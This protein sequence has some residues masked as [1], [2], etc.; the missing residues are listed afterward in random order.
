MT[1]DSKSETRGWKSEA[2]TTLGLITLVNSSCNVDVSKRKSKYHARA[3][4]HA[5]ACHVPA[6]CRT[7]RYL[8]QTLGYMETKKIINLS[9]N[10]PAGSSL[11]IR[12]F[13]ASPFVRVRCPFTKSKG[14]GGYFLGYKSTTNTAPPLPEELASLLNSV[15]HYY[16][17]PSATLR[18][19]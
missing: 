16:R 13:C 15:S 18:I 8:L 5:T 7:T 19:S 14:T 12:R 2:P 1:R 10:A 3:I 6:D 11:D 4:P 9:S 17:G